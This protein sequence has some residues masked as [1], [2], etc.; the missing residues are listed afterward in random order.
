MD[1]VFLT[2]FSIV[3]F[4][5][6]FKK[7]SNSRMWRVFARAGTFQIAYLFFTPYVDW[8]IIIRFLRMTNSDMSW[9]GANGRSVFMRLSGR[10]IYKTSHTS[11]FSEKNRNSF[12]SLKERS[13]WDK[14]PRFKK[15]CF[16]AC[17]LLPCCFLTDGMS[18]L[19][20]CASSGHFRHQ[21]MLT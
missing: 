2:W 8:L 12:E 16:V 4:Y 11:D 5:Y 18:F 1:F 15:W 10:L 20:V 3:T 21:F 7:W 19:R 6:R 9:H 17:Y 14:R 13:P